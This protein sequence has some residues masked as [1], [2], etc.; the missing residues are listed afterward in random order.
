MYRVITFTIRYDKKGDLK[1]KNY[2]VNCYEV[3]PETTRAFIN[4][5]HVAF[6]L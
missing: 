3:P 5:N 4:V 1:V 6:W 2:L